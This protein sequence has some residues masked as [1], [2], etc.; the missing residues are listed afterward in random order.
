MLLEHYEDG[1][2]LKML[3]WVGIYRLMKL[4]YRY[5]HFPSK[6]ILY[7]A[8]FMSVRV[9]VACKIA[10]SRG[11][12]SKSQRIHQN[13]TVGAVWAHS[14]VQNSTIACV[15]TISALTITCKMAPSR[16]RWI[17]PDFACLLELW[18]RA[19]CVHHVRDL[20][21][22]I[23]FCTKLQMLWNFYGDFFRPFLMLCKKFSSKRCHLE[24]LKNHV[25]LVCKILNHFHSNSHFSQHM[26]AF[27]VIQI[28]DENRLP[29]L[30]SHEVSCQNSI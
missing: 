14:R 21:E 17:C 12:Y 6:D 8:A 18:S 13:M 1:W 26:K 10:W 19:W 28:G 4:Y 22:P 5:P 27:D 25:I 11:R 15:M 2:S 16:A 24:G 30:Q 9:L 29:G 20:A 3:I 23:T 7:W